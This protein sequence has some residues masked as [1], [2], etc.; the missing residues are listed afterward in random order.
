MLIWLNLIPACRCVIPPKGNRAVLGFPSKDFVS[1][2]SSDGDLPTSDDPG[3]VSGDEVIDA[4]LAFLAED[5]DVGDSNCSEDCG[6]WDLLPTTGD[7]N[8][9]SS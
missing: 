6:G 1:T 4:T 2:A 5:S 8:D 3:E 9:G 7:V